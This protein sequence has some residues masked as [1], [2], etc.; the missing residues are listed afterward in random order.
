M[1]KYQ[2][3]STLEVL[4]GAD[5][6]NKWIA[7]TAMSSL[8]SP[9]LE[10]GAGTG[11]ISQFFS[12]R[13]GVYLSDVDTNLVKQLKKRFAE[14]NT[15]SVLQLDIRKPAQDKYREYFRSIF[16]INV[17]E[18]IEDDEKALAN[19]NTL[20]KKNGELM[21]LV[22]AKQFAYTRLDKD[23]GHYRRYEKKELREKVENAGFIINEMFY[24]N[25]VG[26]LSWIIRDKVERENIQLKPYQVALFDSI[27]P[28]LRVIESTIKPPVGISL[29]V[30]A[31]KN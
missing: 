5:H 11:N 4:E 16:G 20:L 12:G 31:R 15:F 29:I 13:N 28:I 23:L 7:E 2:G 3:I 25:I 27:V 19:L 6:Y 18:H 26:L 22:P 14:D 8:S 24:F 9:I 1:T 17:L 10:I 21:L 30:R